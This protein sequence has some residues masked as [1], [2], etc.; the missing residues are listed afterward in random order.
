M[1]G[2]L[3]I[4][5]A[6]SGAGKTTIVKRLLEKPEFKLE[7]S[8]SAC[9]RKIRENEVDGK[10]YYFFSIEEFKSKIVN[11]EFIEWEEVYT[12]Y[13]YGT[14]KTEIDRITQK[15][16][17]ILFDVDVKGGINLKNQFK[18]NA[19]SLFIMPPS[20]EELERR[21][22]NRKANDKDDLKKRIDKATEELSYHVNFDKVILNDD[23]D[24]AVEEAENHLK[25]FLK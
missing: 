14:L 7:F 1:A 11:Q 10:D 19:L 5:S 21:L 18:E 9:S 22:I 25:K 17:N 16:N 13:F 20:I 24:I 12:D 15:G 2:K 23:L 8:I 4:V 6:P 3:I